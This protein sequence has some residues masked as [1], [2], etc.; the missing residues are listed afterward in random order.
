M[1]LSFPNKIPLRAPKCCFFVVFS[2]VSPKI[3]FP[4]RVRGGGGGV[5]GEGGELDGWQKNHNSIM[6]VFL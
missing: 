1:F 3:A 6:K 2:N 4:G 5:G